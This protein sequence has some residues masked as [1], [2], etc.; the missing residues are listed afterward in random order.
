MHNF[1]HIWILCLSSK[2]TLWAMHFQQITTFPRVITP[3]CFVFPILHK[4]WYHCSKCTN[5]PIFC[6]LR[7]IWEKSQYLRS[8][9]FKSMQSMAWTYQTVLEGTAFMCALLC[10]PGVWALVLWMQCCVRPQSLRIHDWLSQVSSVPWDCWLFWINGLGPDFHCS[11]SA[12][13]ADMT[14]AAESCISPCSIDNVRS[15]YV[16]IQ[17]L[18]KLELHQFTTAED[19]AK[20][21]KIRVLF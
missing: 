6:C 7:I 13:H 5:S 16:P 11:S 10:L 14:P 17:G 18:S 9:C 20:G 8:T 2:D 1:I 21:A 12:L 15:S 19:P 3:S 4:P